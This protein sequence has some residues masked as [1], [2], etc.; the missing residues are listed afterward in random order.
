MKPLRL[1]GRVLDVLL[2]V[3]NPTAIRKVRPQKPEPLPNNVRPL[4]QRPMA[5]HD[6][7]AR[8]RNRCVAH[9]VVE[10]KRPNL[11]NDEIWNKWIADN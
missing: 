6:D 8:Q 9:C 10:K 1:F 3:P 5:G 4:H 2:G 11:T 7:E